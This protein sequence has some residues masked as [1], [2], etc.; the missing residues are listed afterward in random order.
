MK[1]GCQ[2]QTFYSILRYW[3]SSVIYKYSDVAEPDRDTRSLM[4]MITLSARDSV[5]HVL[6]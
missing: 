2:L 6:T 4:Y 1:L 5:A 3:P